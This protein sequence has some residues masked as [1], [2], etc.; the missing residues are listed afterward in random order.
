MSERTELQPP[1]SADTAAL[2]DEVWQ[3]L[4][5]DPVHLSPKWFYDTAGSN[6]FEEIT[7]LPEYYLSR[8]EEELLSDWGTGWLA[9]WAPA[10]LVELGA[11]SARKTR[12]LLEALQRVRPG[13]WY[14][15]VDVA[16]DFLDET[17]AALR[18]E[19]PRLEVQPVVADLTG[20]LE[21]PPTLPRPAGFA[22]LGSTL[23]NFATE[24]AVALLRRVAQ[25]MTS[26]DRFV[27]GVDL[28]P[29]ARK[30]EAELIAAYDDEAGVTA[31]FNLNMLEVLNR[32]AGTDFDSGDF[33][34][35]A[36]YN[37]A[38]GRIEMHLRARRDVQVGVPGRGFVPIGQGATIRTEISCKYDRSVIDTLL[39][40]AGMTCADW[41]E[42]THGRYA[43]VVAKRA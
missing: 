23:G 15:P 13:A 17:A 16:A 2:R 19:F 36:R 27:L 3:R 6:L 41:V 38:E 35:E 34:H 4:N 33:V 28:R 12:V 7:Q 30:S 10:S 18:A 14:V 37:R 9:E 32:A 8:T 39:G 25:A 11:G 1:E 40:A 29:G 5:A 43:M 24:A 31:R 21:V 26:D 20:E 42:D 22:L